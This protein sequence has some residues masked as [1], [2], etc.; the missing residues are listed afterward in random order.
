MRKSR[1]R[2]VRRD[3]RKAR[4]SGWKRPGRSKSGRVGHG[5]GGMK[6][7]SWQHPTIKPVITRAPSIDAA[8]KFK[9]WL[10]KSGYELTADSNGYKV[11]RNGVQIAVCKT[12]ENLKAAVEFIDMYQRSPCLQ[13]AFEKALTDVEL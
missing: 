10:K 9:K 3:R 1:K 5:G 8:R 7:S 12:L 2:S 6:A 13:Q 11:S 4:A